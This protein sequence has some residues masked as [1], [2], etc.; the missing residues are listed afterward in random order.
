MKRTK[1]PWRWLSKETL[2]GDH[3]HRPVII[4]ANQK[5]QLVQRNEEGLLRPIDPKHPDMRALAGAGRLIE[6]VE[7]FFKL[8]T[9][10][11]PEVR[12]PEECAALEE[13]E[14]S[15][16]AAGGSVPYDPETPHSVKDFVKRGMELESEGLDPGPIGRHP[17]S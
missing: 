11:F 14:E 6:A 17:K 16:R 12:G 15:L 10:I 5:G 1:G 8:R 13:L 2:V 7:A 9:S 3:G 4:S